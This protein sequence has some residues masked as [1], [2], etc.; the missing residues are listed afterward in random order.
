MH[1]SKYPIKLISCLASIYM[2]SLCADPAAN[3]SLELVDENRSM[4]MQESCVTPFRSMHVGLRH[5]EAEGIGYTNGYTTLE[6]F[7]IY[8]YN[9][10]FMPFLDLRGHV[11][12]DGKLAGNVGIGARSY[13]EGINHLFGYYLYYDIRQSSH[14]LMPQQLSPGVEL[15]GKRMEYRINGYFPVGNQKSDGYDY[16]FKGFK[17][18][19]II[20][21]FKK[22]YVMEGADAEVGV[23]LTQK[24]KYD[25]YLGAGPY[26][27]NAS[28]GSAWGGKIRINGKYKQYALVEASYSYDHIFGNIVQGSVGISIPFG[29]KIRQK[30]SECSKNTN[31]VFARAAQSPYR[32]EI[33]IVQKSNLQKKAINPSTGKPWVVWFIDNT[34]SSSGTFDNPF[35]TLAQ[36]QTISKPNDMI[37]IFPGNGTALSGGIVL[38]DNQTLFGAGISQ[39]IR[40]GNGNIRIPAFSKTYPLL[41]G[42]GTGIV[43]LANNNEVSGIMLTTNTSN[44]LIYGFGMVNGYI[45]N[46]IGSGHS[47][48]NG[49]NITG[50]G[51]YTIKNNHLSAPLGSSGNGIS[52]TAMIGLEDATFEFINNNVTGFNNGMFLSANFEIGGDFIAVG[53][54]VSESNGYGIFFLCFNGTTLS[55]LTLDRNI[56]NSSS[57]D[58]IHIVTSQP[59]CGIVVNNQINNPGNNGI[60][61]ENDGT[62]KSLIIS[63]NFIT[64]P[65]STFHGVSC[66]TFDSLCLNLT[67]NVVENGP[68]FYLGAGDDAQM[69]LNI[70]NNFGTLITQLS[71]GT[72]LLDSSTNCSCP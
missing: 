61:F 6:G 54:T 13:L 66:L 3:E 12:D 1:V 15:L 35:S 39:T 26:Y 62:S 59:F 49:I 50:G 55:N 7:G 2:H 19:N 16:D 4:I 25:F 43:T 10:R 31:L 41:T 11:F 33:P 36:A 40:T 67:N 9:D 23:H 29:G 56:V 64:N 51:T 65:P 30:K 68:G 8:N 27:L 17:G 63:N 38:K 21:K 22:Q 72:I 14:H 32:F 45:H 53:N 57:L 46:N 42:S 52:G 71:P 34:S 44:S 20:L 24:T 28:H 58:A 18:N 48:S 70:S 60:Y 47:N 5:I 69:T 37:Y